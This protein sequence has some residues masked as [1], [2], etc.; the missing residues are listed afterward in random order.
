MAN[1]LHLDSQ[2]VAAYITKL[3]ARRNLFINLT[4]LQKLLYC[5]YGSILA[6]SDTRICEEHPKAWQHGPVFPRVYNYTK[7]HQDDLINALLRKTES[8]ESFL[9]PSQIALIADVIDFFGNKTAGELVTWSHHPNGAWYKCTN[10]GRNLHH[11]IPDTAI[12]EYF[13]RIIKVQANG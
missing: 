9:N 11:E 13:Q 2:D 3:C 6:T 7:K 10:G 12:I 5:V 4:K 8:V 1:E